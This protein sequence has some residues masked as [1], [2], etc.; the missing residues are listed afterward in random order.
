MKILLLILLSVSIQLS[1]LN[2][3]QFVKI[4]E[5][6]F[7]RPVFLLSLQFKPKG[8]KFL[9]VVEQTGRIWILKNKNNRELLLDKQKQICS[10]G[11]EEG[12]LGVAA[13]TDFARNR[14]LYIYYSVCRPR[15]TLISRLK[16]SGDRAPFK[17]KE[18][19][20][21]TIAQ[22]YSN[23][24]GGMLAFG[25]DGYLYVGTGDGGSGGDP[26]QNSQNLKSNLGKIL[27]LDVS[28]GMGY[29]PAPGNP[30]QGKN[31]E[32]R[33]IYAYGMRNPWR[34]SFDLISGLLIAADVGQ[35]KYEEID[36][37]V[38]GGNYGWNKMEGRHCFPESAVCETG[39]YQLPVLEYGRKEG[40]CIIGGY[41]YRGKNLPA[42]NG[43]YIFGDFVNG[44]VWS[45]GITGKSNWE[46][47]I[48]LK[49]GLNINS[50]AAD[51]AGELYILTLQGWVYRLS[52]RG[53]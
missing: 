5:Q 6:K 12:L 45:S 33:L 35:D 4:T 9:S 38:K 1:K 32:S 34:F 13:D 48:L 37:I 36:L 52:D 16:I 26:H 24:N 42:L 47:K 25:P 49:T 21:L 44:S 53:N 31:G 19:P 8:E 41:V 2:A 29:K 22:P 46:K 30:F 20:L 40:Q 14:K 15:R 18:E 7:E 43:R 10:E 23:H 39:R 50:F 27:R 11:A 17:I 3:Y 28:V 51:S